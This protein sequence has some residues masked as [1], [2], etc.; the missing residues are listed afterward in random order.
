MSTGD[1][2]R[3]PRSRRGWSRASPRPT[4]QNGARGHGT[5]VYMTLLFTATT[6]YVVSGVGVVAKRA[7]GR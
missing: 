1:T 4:K 7:L 6:A 3:D 5:G 2:A